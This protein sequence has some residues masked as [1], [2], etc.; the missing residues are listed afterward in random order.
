VI[1]VTVNP[2]PEPVINADGPTTFCDG[3]SVNLSVD[4]FFDIFWST[5]ATTES[6]NVTASGS[7]SVTVTDANGCSAT[8]D[9]MDISVMDCTE[10]TITPDGATAFCEGGSVTLSSNIAEG[11]IWSTGATTQSI[12][13]SESGDYSCSNGENVSNTIS[14][15]VNTN[16]TPVISADGPTTFCEG[17]SV[18][19]SVDSFFDI[20]WSNGETTASIS[21]TEAGA[22]SVSVTDDNG[23]SGTSDEVTVT[24][25][26]CGS[27]ITISAD[28]A[29][30]FCAGGSVTLTSSAADGNVWSTGET[31]QSIVVTESGD[32]VCSNGEFVSNT[33]SVM[34]IEASTISVA[35]IGPDKICYDGSV[36]LTATA[37][38]GDLQWYR[39]GVAI[40]G[41]NNNMLE[42][43]EIG[44]YACTVD[45]AVC[46]AA[47][48]N[49]VKVTYYKGSEI[50]PAGT[51]YICPGGS[52]ILS[53][54]YS[55]I[56]T[57]QWY[58][59]GV[60]IP[61]AT[62]AAFEATVGGDYSVV[63]TKSGCGRISKTAKVVVDCRLAPEQEITSHIW[64]NPASENVMLLTNANDG[65]QLVITIFDINGSIVLQQTHKQSFAG[66]EIIL[67]IYNLAVGLYNLQVLFPN[68]TVNQHSLVINK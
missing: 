56:A 28:G 42:V 24:V 4:S 30:E 18:N 68:G 19:L 14:V 49:T 39:N 16:P 17:G 45:N 21:V 57:Y 38:S 32:Y 52:V 3:G 15:V 22:Y 66:E 31:T 27:E 36:L 54:P 11:N 65:D 59:N 26:S 55:V 8:S 23:C 20:F 6:I 41:A 51:S 47:T 25:E 9:A 40:S 43:T 13:V 1:S 44:L 61:G 60:L 50:T 35:P 12:V 62:G 5:G 53:T 7:Y 46:D 58:R 34:V 48:S 64:P 63:I 10:L 67:P 2:N 29:T 37:S 33:I